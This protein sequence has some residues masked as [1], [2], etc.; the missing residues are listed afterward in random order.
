MSIPRWVAGGRASVGSSRDTML[1]SRGFGMVSPESP[2]LG[3]EHRGIYRPHPLRAAGD[4]SGIQPEGQWPLGVAVKAGPLAGFGATDQAGAERVALDI[5][6]EHQATVD[7]HRRW[8][9]VVALVK[10]LRPHFGVNVEN[11]LIYNGATAHDI[12]PHL[13]AKETGDAIATG[14]R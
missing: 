14:L 2:Q 13:T 1:I 3:L 12:L 6:Q 10:D 5:S 11:H 8:G 9:D 7:Q 4:R